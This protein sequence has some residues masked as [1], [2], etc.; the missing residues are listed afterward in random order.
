[1][2]SE[3]RL[4]Q[5]AKPGNSTGAGELV[6]LRLTHGAKAQSKNNLVEELS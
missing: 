4:R 6:P 2:A 5:Q 1:M 3:V